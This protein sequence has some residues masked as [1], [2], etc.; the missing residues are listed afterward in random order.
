MT[1]HVY[2]ILKDGHGVSPQQVEHILHLKIEDKVAHFNDKQVFFDELVKR[3]DYYPL[4]RFIF[5]SQD[6]LNSN[7]NISLYKACFNAYAW[8]QISSLKIAELSSVLHGNYPLHIIL[9]PET[10]S[11]VD[12]LW[13]VNVPYRDFLN[14]NQEPE[15]L[16]E[17][18]KYNPVQGYSRNLYSPKPVVFGP[19]TVKAGETVELDFEYRDRKG[20][21]ASCDF[22]TYIKYDAGYLPKNIVSVKNGRAKVKVTALGLESGDHITCK[23]SIGKVY[24]NAVQHTIEVV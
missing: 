20:E 23:F 15:L 13:V 4:S 16:I 1:L 3:S 12:A 10:K 24:T 9:Y 19:T 2:E 7:S 5:H 21:F 6:I 18:T 11:F 22:N 14:C 17:T 8:T